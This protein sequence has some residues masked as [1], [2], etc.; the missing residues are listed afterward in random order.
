MAHRVCPVWIGY[1]L[2]VPI[3]KLWQSPKKILSAYMHGGMTVLDVG[4]AMGYFSIPM[5]RMVGA[6]GKVVSVDMQAGML[7][8]LR[9]RAAKA[10]LGD[11]IETHLCGQNS[12]QLE[13][14]AESIDFALAFAVVHEV[15]D[16][17]KLFQEI[18]AALKP[19]ARLLVAEP[20][21]H[22]TD[23][24]FAETVSLAGQ[25]GFQVAGEPRISRSHAVL[26]QKR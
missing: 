2:L 17:R 11:R 3:R 22:V 8:V 6:L 7:S 24:D 12:L 23:Q 16:S 4:S 15:P 21:G 5:A 20:R 18:A 13:N 14:F 19:D 9:K 25:Q 26:L 1:L 10:G